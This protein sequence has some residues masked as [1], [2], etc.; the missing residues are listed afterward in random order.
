MKAIELRI[1]NIVSLYG[2]ESTII[3]NDFQKWFQNEPNWENRAFKPIPLTVEWL[4]RFSAINSKILQGECCL[5]LKDQYNLIPCENYFEFLT[6]GSSIILA[7]I[8]YVHQLQN[9]YFAL[10]GEEL[11][12]N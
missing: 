10:T 9:L 3:P 4:F 12:I 1:G 11:T 8:F 2:S 6:I 7:D 5:R